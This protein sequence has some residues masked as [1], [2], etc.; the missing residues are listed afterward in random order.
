M[1]RVLEA[2]RRE[3]RSA[4]RG[5]PRADDLV[6]LPRQRLDACA[7][8][9]ASALR[10]LVQKS[11]TRFAQVAGRLP[12]PEGNAR[13]GLASASMLRA[14]ASAAR[15][16]PIRAR[17]TRAQVRIASRLHPRLLE[18]RLVRHRDRLDGMGRRAI[19]ALAR[20]AA[21]RRTR[22]E[23]ISGRLRPSILAGRLERCRERLGV[24]D[25]RAAQAYRNVIRHR[26]RALDSQAQ[27]LGSLSY[28]AVLSRGYA[29]V[30]DAAG[31]MVRSAAAVA[32]GDRLEI[33]FADGHVDA[34]ARGV[35]SGP[36]RLEAAPAKTALAKPPGKSGQGSL[37]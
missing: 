35:A 9:L 13:P 28:Q 12:S 22:L 32:P 8:R 30:R 26:R 1:R 14:A 18:T 5:L 20:T 27:L 33:E 36:K 25:A 29:L 6:A 37:F 24:L 10:G 23:R 17:I 19:E 16:L 21:S 11:H 15:S 3:L 34:E 4:A 7:N 31:I 2:H